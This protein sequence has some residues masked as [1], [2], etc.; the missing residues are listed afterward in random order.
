MMKTTSISDIIR[1][2]SQEE[3]E[4]LFKRIQNDNNLLKKYGLER[5]ATKDNGLMLPP[6]DG[7][8]TGVPKKPEPK[9]GK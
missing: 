4:E 3:P 6:D 7:T 1:E 8:N 2:T 9:P 5:V